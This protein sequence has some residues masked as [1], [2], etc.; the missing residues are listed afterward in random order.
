VTDL[1]STEIRELLIEIRDLLLPV[2]DAYRD[3]YEKRLTQRE[4][5]RQKEVQELLKN[6]KRAQAW[7]L[8]D[9]SRSQSDIAKQVSMDLGNA[10][11]FFKRLRE[12][13]AI[14]T[15]AK[16]MRIELKDSGR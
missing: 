13:N 11:R 10:S 4:A 12:L 9:G 3:E 15:S 2:A 6:P 16:P 1:S 7:K 8:A 14:T 5:E